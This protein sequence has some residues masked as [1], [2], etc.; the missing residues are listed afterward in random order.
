MGSG[1]PHAIA[2]FV[3][4]LGLGWDLIV[5]VVGMVEAIAGSVPIVWTRAIFRLQTI[6]GFCVDKVV[7]R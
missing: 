1:T 5:M 4:V 6:L 7:V 2:W 3:P